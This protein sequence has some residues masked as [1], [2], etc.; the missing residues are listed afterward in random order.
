MERLV[1]LDDLNQYPE[2]R[3]KGVSV[4]QMFDFDNYEGGDNES[5]VE[6]KP[7]KKKAAAK[8]TAKKK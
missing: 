8:K 4:N 3:S 6:N 1:T 2:L 7:V 5:P